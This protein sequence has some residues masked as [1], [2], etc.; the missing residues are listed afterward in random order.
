MAKQKKSRLAKTI[1]VFVVLMLILSLL[2]AFVVL[3]QAFF[4]N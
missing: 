3:I 4:L 2:S 1:Q